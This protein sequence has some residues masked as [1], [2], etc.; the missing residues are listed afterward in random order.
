MVKK[1]VFFCGYNEVVLFCYG[2]YRHEI[3]AENVTRSALLN[4]IV[5]V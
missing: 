3:P 5:E 2:I 4:L 1:A